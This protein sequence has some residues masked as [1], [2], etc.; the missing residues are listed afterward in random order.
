MVKAMAPNAPMGAKRMMMPTTF[1]R[2]SPK[3]WMTLR[4]NCPF[5]PMA[6]RPI[7]TSTE[8]NITCRRSPLAKAS[9]ALCG[10]MLAMISITLW[11]WALPAIVATLL[12]SRLS[13]WR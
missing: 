13:T 5:G 2:I 10:M 11:A 12:A 3:A 4:G 8:K 6:A 1:I 7:P 9:T